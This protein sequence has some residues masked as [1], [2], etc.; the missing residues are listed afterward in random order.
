MNVAIIPARGGSKRIPQKNVRFFAGKPIIAYSIQA[1][2]ESGLFDRIIVST[3]SAEVA[4]VAQAWGAEVPFRRPE[5]LATDY[6]NIS[7]VLLHAVEWA[8]ANGGCDYFCCIY[9]TA[10]FLQPEFL[11]RGL[12]EM[13]KKGAKATMSVARFSYPI[14]RALKVGEGECLEMIQPEFFDSRS[15]DLQDCYHDAAQF[16]WAEADYFIKQRVFVLA[17][18]LAVVIPSKFVHDIDTLEDWEIAELKYR[19]LQRSSRETPHLWTDLPANTARIVLGTAQLGFSYGISNRLG[20][21]DANEANNILCKAWAGGIRLYDT[22]QAYGDSEY[23]L[24]DFFAGSY[25]FSDVRFMSKLHPNVDTRNPQMIR[26]HAQ[27][28]LRRLK[29]GRL[30][31]LLLHREQHIDEWNGPLGNELRLL[32]EEGAVCHLG[33]SVYNPEYAQRALLNPDISVVELPGGT[34][35]RRMARAGITRLAND[36]NKILVV[37]SIFLQGLAFLPPGQVPLSVPHAREAVVALQKFCREHNLNPIEFAYDYVRGLYPDALV[38]I[39]ADT[40]EQVASNCR[41]AQ[42]PGTSL[43]LLQAWD[44]V[45][46]NDFEGLYDP[47]KWQG[48]LEMNA[49][50][51]SEK[52]RQ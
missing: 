33:V 29:T 37:R 31:S 51:F 32:R 47:S 25:G 18:P 30:W 20:K 14:Q 38:V 7:E 10:P 46:P 35:D 28:S 34:F 16:Y 3:E 19:A 1:A 27:E 9:S 39:G 40:S 41:L 12:E 36:V 42:R 8:K 2:K 11:R 49:W 17:K 24:G 4:Q 43:E 22:A 21:P 26:Q 45:W 5:H 15:Q 44:E 48:T 50:A 13:Q 6:V 52:T 23:V